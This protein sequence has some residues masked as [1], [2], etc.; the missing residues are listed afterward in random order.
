[1]YDIE[2]SIYI[3]A[4]FISVLNVKNLLTFIVTVRYRRKVTFIRFAYMYDW[5]HI[6]ALLGDYIYKR[7]DY[8]SRLYY[9]LKV[10]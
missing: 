7:Y 2:K 4:V 1:V 9:R 8:Y 5:T 3:F 10:I 6:S